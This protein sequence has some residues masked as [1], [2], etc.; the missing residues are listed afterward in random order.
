MST[1]LLLLAHGARDPGWARPFERVAHRIAAARPATPM[2]LA[3]LDFMAPDAK[4]AGDQL[5]AKGCTRVAIVPLFLGAG[6]HVLK[7]L[8][9]LRDQLVQAHPGVRWTLQPAIGEDERVIEVI[10]SVALLSSDQQ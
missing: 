5:V 2:V 8:P 3:F 1:G 9:A 6:G 7:D 4:Q 10:A